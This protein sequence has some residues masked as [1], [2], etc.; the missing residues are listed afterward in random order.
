MWET[1]SGTEKD[2]LQKC[3]PVKKKGWNLRI[4]HVERGKTSLFHRSCR[5]H[6]VDAIPS[7]SLSLCFFLVVDALS[8]CPRQYLSTG[9]VSPV[10]GSVRWEQQG[11]ISAPNWIRFQQW[12]NLWCWSCVLLLIVTNI[13]QGDGHE[14]AT[15][16]RVDLGHAFLPPLGLSEARWG[17]DFISWIPGMSI[18][19][20]HICTIKAS[21]IRFWQVKQVLKMTLFF[22]MFWWYLGCSLHLFS[23]YL[24]LCLRLLPHHFQPWEAGHAICKS[25][26]GLRT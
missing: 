14:N 7:L 12:Q 17:V 3:F 24:H 6:R 22:W 21:L 8:L 13:K 10:A 20:L 2:V 26:W 15:G 1:R 5:T 23:P 25:R 16:R 11:K 19:S 4:L 9:H 18:F